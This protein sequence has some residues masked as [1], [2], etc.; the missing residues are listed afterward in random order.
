MTRSRK[1][2]RAVLALAALMLAA[3]CEKRPTGFD[4]NPSRPEGVTSADV[5]LV[6]FRNAALRVLV[7]DYASP[8]IDSVS[9][10]ALA[11]DGP[12]SMPLLLVFDGTPSNSFELFRRDDGGRF[13]RTTDFPIQSHF[14]FVNEGFEEFFTPD[15]APSHYAPATYLA[16]GLL[17]GL[18][19]HASPLSNESVMASAGVV[20]ITYNGDLQPLDSL[21]TIAWIGVPGAV[22]YWIHAF[23]KPIA[24]AQRLLSA[25]PSPVAYFT[26]GDLLIGF[27]AGNNPGGT[28][29][30]RLG[31]PL[32]TLKSRAPLLGHDYY[33]RVSGVDATGQVIAQTV[34]D[35]DSL[36]LSADLAFLAPPSF[37]AEK[38]KVYFSIGGTKVARRALPHGPA[39]VISGEPG[40]ASPVGTLERH[41]ADLH[42]PVIR[43]IQTYSRVTRPARR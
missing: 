16:R 40:D 34:G 29:S 42:F 6:T 12:E 26:T 2:F 11:F 33:I 35:L 36:S 43:P 4:P 13:Q 27:Y 1:W 25:L 30:Y 23:E 31:Q 9:V 10:G 38:T 24:G 21:F 8:N 37:T 20:P 14:K 15:V 18:S 19:T 41:V 22:G 39:S 28:I 7:R 5:K 17:D 32:F 3:G